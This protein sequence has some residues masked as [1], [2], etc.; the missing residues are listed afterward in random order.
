MI[1][2]GGLRRRP[3]FHAHSVWNPRTEPAAKRSQV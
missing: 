3:H 1:A 2:R